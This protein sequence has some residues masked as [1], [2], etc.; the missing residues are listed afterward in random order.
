ML[1][2]LLNADYTAGRP[3]L[4]PRG[5][6][7]SPRAG[8]L[9]HPD[10]GPLKRYQVIFFDLDDTLYPADN[11]VWAM[12]SERISRYMTERMKLPAAQV[13]SL[14][15]KYAEEQG[16]TLNGLMQ[17]FKVDPGDYL[18]FVHDIDLSSLLKPDP[19]LRRMLADLPQ[20]K[21]VFTNASRNHAERV[22]GLLGVA[23]EFDDIIDIVA[24][25]Y[26]NK[27]DLQAYWTA[28]AIAGSP[29]E[30]CLMVDDRVRN[31]EPAAVL[32]MGTV[33]VGTRDKPTEAIDLQI[34]SIHRLLDR[35][36]EL[37]EVAA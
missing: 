8:S 14:R 7:A 9:H 18:A 37:R 26:V 31:L 5:P 32:G 22:L 36:P 35:V 25:R 19:A 33:L 34:E 2:L 6:V 28:L 20:T 10:E 15:R 11:G 30:G 4:C 24:V 29:A 27:P 1:A 3:I 12:I 21:I 16:T 23:S 17:D 13:A